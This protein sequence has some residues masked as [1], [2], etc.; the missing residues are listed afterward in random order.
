MGL[1]LD[2]S[3]KQFMKLYGEKKYVKK[4]S[5]EAIK[6]L[7]ATISD[8]QDEVEYTS[9]VDWK[10]LFKHSREIG[11]TT[12]INEVGASLLVELAAPLLALARNRLLGLSDAVNERLNNQG[13]TTDA[14]L[15]IELLPAFEK[16]DD[17]HEGAA[18]IIA[19]HK[20][21]IALS[22]GYYL[23]MIQ[24]ADYHYGQAD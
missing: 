8:A 3:T 9:D 13:D 21:Y 15:L 6:I 16:S 23:I 20:G 11:D 7:L 10:V 24:A 18:D 4:F 19:E 22:H 17:W 5:R 14:D 2:L 12:V 1:K